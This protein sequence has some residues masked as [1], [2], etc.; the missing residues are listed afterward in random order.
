MALQS[1]IEV[2]ELKYVIWFFGSSLF[3]VQRFWKVII[4][5]THS[6]EVSE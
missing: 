4:G 6:I 1:R 3:P 2:P 5:F